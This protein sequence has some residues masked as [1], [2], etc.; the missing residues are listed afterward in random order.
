MKTT[1]A[2]Y[3]TVRIRRE[4]ELEPIEDII[5]SILAEPTMSAEREA[6]A[7]RGPIL[8]YQRDASRNLDLI[9]EIEGTE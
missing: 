5:D 7:M 3:T 1:E 4:S 8:P 9:A 6:D 2:V